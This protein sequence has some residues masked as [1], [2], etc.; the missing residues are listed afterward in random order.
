MIKRF[1]K[2][3]TALW[4]TFVKEAKNATFLF[5]RG[6]MDYH[7]DRFKDHS[8][9]LFADG[10]LR[11]LFVANENNNEIISH[12][13]LSYGGLLLEPEA[14]L[15]D[16][17]TWFF[18][19]VRYYH[20]LGFERVIY[21]CLPFYY[22]TYPAQEDLY[23]LF[24]LKAAL[25]QRDTSSVFVKSMPLPYQQRRK[26]NSRQNSGSFRISRANDPTEFW[27]DVLIP[28]LKEKF[29]AEPVHSL[30]EI[31][32][33]MRLFPNQIQLFEVRNKGLLGGT[34][35]YSTPLTAHAQYTS[36]NPLGKEMEAQDVLFHHL[37]SDVFQE[38]A[39]FSFGTSNGDPGRTLNR[40]LVNWKEGFGARTFAVDTY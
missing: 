20:Q 32:K 22:A 12:E 30:E 19:F 7:A 2:A 40:G 9:L 8:L 11:A 27:N 28:N 18:H 3:D 4:N 36:A 10:K 37:L 31:K 39:Y 38:K 34:V 13:G 16:V 29:G 21:K 5:D 17:L 1:E 6:Y 33:L 24:L 14:R 35:I 15:E 25:L 23:A 26:K